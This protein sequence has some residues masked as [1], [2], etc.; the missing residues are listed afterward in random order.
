MIAN[1]RSNALTRTPSYRMGLTLGELVIAT[2][3]VMATLVVAAVLFLPAS[4]G[5]REPARRSQCKNNL[6]QI[7]LALFNYHDQYNALPPA[8]TVDADG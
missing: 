5:A 8:Y 6:K 3:I 7:A 1:H 4:R 2:G